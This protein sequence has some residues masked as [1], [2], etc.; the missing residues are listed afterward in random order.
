[1]GT[2][3]GAQKGMNSALHAEREDVQSRKHAKGES[4]NGGTYHA[5][6]DATAAAVANG[7]TTNGHERSSETSIP[8][9][10]VEGS[11]RVGP[12]SAQDWRANLQYNG[13]VSLL[14]LTVIVAVVFTVCWRGPS[15]RRAGEADQI[16]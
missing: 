9:S 10:S 7:K 8:E 11:D 13:L 12:Q 5:I 2:S 4:S 15:G 6:V 16:V 3:S 1:M 14:G